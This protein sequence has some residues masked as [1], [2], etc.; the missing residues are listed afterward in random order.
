MLPGYGKVQLVIWELVP[1]EVGNT[2]GA[3][4]DVVPTEWGNTAGVC[5]ITETVLVVA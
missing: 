4:A 2:A 3:D 5:V 1:T